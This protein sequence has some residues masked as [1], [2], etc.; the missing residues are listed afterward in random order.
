MADSEHCSCRV[1]HILFYHRVCDVERTCH[2][3]WI[4][5]LTC[6]HTLSYLSR[7]SALKYE[8]TMLHKPVYISNTTPRLIVARLKLNCSTWAVV[9]ERH[10]VYTCILVRI[11]VCIYIYIDVQACKICMTSSIKAVSTLR[12]SLGVPHPST[13]RAFHCLTSEFKWDPVCSAE[14]GRQ[15]VCRHYNVSYDFESQDNDALIE[16]GRISISKIEWIT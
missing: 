15:R 14:Y 13:N 11:F 12:G 3:A 7:Y 5:H 16:C 6:S 4:Q 9:S 8:T 1:Y 10:I 2:V